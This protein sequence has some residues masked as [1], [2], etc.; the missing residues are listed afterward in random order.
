MLNRPCL[1]VP[2]NREKV[3]QWFEEKTPLDAEHAAQIQAT[4][5]QQ[6][7]SDAAVCASLLKRAER[8]HPKYCGVKRTNNPGVGEDPNICE[9]WVMDGDTVVYL[10]RYA[11]PDSAAVAHDQAIFVMGMESAMQ[12]NF[13]IADY[14]DNLIEQLRSFLCIEEYVRQLGIGHPSSHRGV[15]LTPKENMVKGKWTAWCIV[16]GTKV[17]SYHSDE[18]DA[19]D[20]HERW[21]AQLG[22]DIAISNTVAIGARYGVENEMQLMVSSP[23]AVPTSFTAMDTNDEDNNGGD[24]GMVRLKPHT[25]NNEPYILNP[26]P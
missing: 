2:E 26:V 15:F 7:I 22:S 13:R 11:S 10:G 23:G 8:L 3:R 16:A 18:G 25:L 19:R 6:D 1:L 14:N 4:K 9:A 24:E 12:M 20:V 21:R 17:Y 5:R